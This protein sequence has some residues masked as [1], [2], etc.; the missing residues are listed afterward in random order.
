LSECMWSS[1]FTCVRLS[2]VSVA[3]ASMKGM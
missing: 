3:D 2:T 1:H